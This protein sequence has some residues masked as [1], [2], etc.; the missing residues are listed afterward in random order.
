[1]RTILAASLLVL[2]AAVACG[3]EAPEPVVTAEPTVGSTPSA[4]GAPATP[5]PTVTVAASPSPTDTPVPSPTVEPTPTSTATDTAQDPD[6]AALLKDFAQLG[7][8]AMAKREWAF[9][10]ALYPDE[11]KAKCSLGDFA[12]L[13][14]FAWAFSG[15]PEGVAYVVEGVTVDGDQGRVES[16]FEKDGVQIELDDDGDEEPD[17]IWRDGKW[18]VHVSPEDLAEE[19]P[20]SLDF[21]AED[22]P[23]TPITS[24]V[25]EQPVTIDAGLLDKLSG[26]PEL[27]GEII[28]TVKSIERAPNIE[29]NLYGKVEAEGVFVSIYYSL[30][31]E[32]NSRI[33]PSTQINDN[34]V[35]ADDRGRQWGT[36]GVDVAE[37][38]ADQMGESDPDKW[39]APGF[40]GITAIAF[41]V[42]DG[43]SGLRLISTRLGIEVSLE[44]PQ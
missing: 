39:V 13:M 27:S 36:A 29:H 43:A 33:Q 10:H 19:D 23:T 15:I 1:M 24:Y 12:G 26:E 20:C 14:T 4:T 31:N 11:F 34:F 44:P 6:R 41:D 7:G 2:L 22:T 30:V 40:T 18:T 5:K 38:F 9:V 3:S 42:P 32:A 16:Y 8:D 17:F 35:L 25:M 28:I 37:A 21:T